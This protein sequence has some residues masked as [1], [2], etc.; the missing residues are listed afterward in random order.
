MSN[1]SGPDDGERTENDGTE[2][3]AIPSADSSAPGEETPERRFTAPS[4]FDGSTQIIETA[5]EPVTEVFAAANPVAPQVIPGHI[6]TPKPPQA[7]RSWGWVI[8]VVLVIAA[9]VAVAILGTVLLTRDATP[10]ASPLATSPLV[11]SA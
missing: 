8:A 1:P 3:V 10:A 6:E 4:G 9:I 2:T 7:R 11:I 5:P